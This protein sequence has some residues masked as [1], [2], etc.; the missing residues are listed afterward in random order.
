MHLRSAFAAAVFLAL[1]LAG[2]AAP[3]KDTTAAAPHEH[4]AP[5]EVGDRPVDAVQMFERFDERPAGVERAMRFLYG[6]FPVGAGQDMNRVTFELPVRAGFMTAVSPT[7][8]DAGTGLT[9]SN[10]H[11]HIHHAHWFRMSN[12]PDDQ[13]YAANLAWVFGTGEERTQGSLH[14]R[15]EADPNGPR[16][17][18]YMAPEVPQV[19]IYMIHNKMPQAASVYVA[20]DVSFVYGD[21]AAIKAASGCP[22]LITGESCHAGE[23]FHSL[24][25]K[26]WGSTFDVARQTLADGNLDGVYNYPVDAPADDP[27]HQPTDALGRMFTAAHDGTAIAAAGHLHPNG[28]STIVANLGP[29]GSACEADLD[30][31]GF[32]GVTLLHSDKMETVPAAAPHSEEY[33]MGATK[34]GWRAP[35]RAGDR[36]TQFAEY[37]N[38]DQASYE[39]MTFVG[40]Y[41][42]PQ[43]VPAPRGPEGCTLANTAPTLLAGDP[44]GGDPAQTVVNRN[45]HAGHHHEGSEYCGIPDYPACDT[46]MAHPEPGLQ[47]SLVTIAN[48]AYT[49]GGRTLTGQAGLPVQVPR[50]SKLTFVNGD[51]ALGGGVRHTVTSCNWPCNGPYVANYPQPNGTF[52]SGKLGNVDPIDGGLYVSSGGPLMGYGPSSDAI[53]SWTLDTKDMEPGLY[54]FYCRIHPWMRGSLEVT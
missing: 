27:T 46:E 8:F 19:L 23:D 11:M 42:D 44:W 18:I 41:T 22:G 17:G 31:D 7:L 5:T 13:Y 45:A 40:L 36:I 48:F 34:Y 15:A 9:P 3:G 52:D 24:Q 30:H 33:Q 16:Y 10:E 25:G 32:P 47:T 20:L 12:D 37:A 50:G 4:P 43:Q 54:S 1:V 21:A 28:M 49:P 35:V 2:C 51:M 39:A 29:A 53:P 14:D 38:A 6:P 26:L